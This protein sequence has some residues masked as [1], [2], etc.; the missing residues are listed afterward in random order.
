MLTTQISVEK[1]RDFGLN[2][3]DWKVRRKKNQTFQIQNRKDASFILAGL[4]EQSRW[5]KIWLISV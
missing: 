3:Q 5:S 2:P 4:W 1:L